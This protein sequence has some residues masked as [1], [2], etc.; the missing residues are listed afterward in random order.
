MMYWPSGLVHASMRKA[1]CVRVFFVL[2]TATS[3]CPAQ[4]VVSTLT[5]AQAAACEERDPLSFQQRGCNPPRGLRK[6]W[7][8]SAQHARLS[9]GEDRHPPPDEPNGRAPG[10]A[11]GFTDPIRFLDSA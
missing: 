7:L 5:Q 8:G 4:R 1:K 3:P 10:A 6:L 9:G 11:L 2:F